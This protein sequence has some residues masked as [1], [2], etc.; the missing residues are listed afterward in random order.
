MNLLKMLWKFLT[1]WRADLKAK[2]AKYLVTREVIKLLQVTHAQELLS[3]PRNEWAMVKSRQVAEIEAARDAKQ[4]DIVDRQSWAYP[5]MPESLHR[6][7]V[8][9]LKNTPYSIRRF[10]ETPIPRR[11]MNLV[12]NSVLQFKWQIKP[13]KEFVDDKDPDR[14]KRIRIATETLKRPN[15]TGES[16][17]DLLE[18]ALEDFLLVGMGVIEHRTTPYFKRPTKMWAVD[19]STIRMFLDWTESAPDRPRYAQMTGLKGE[20]GIVT[21]LSDE[22]LVIRDNIRTATPF[23]LGRMEVGFNSVNAFLGVQDMSAKAGADQIHKTWLWWEQTINTA[24]IQQLR[25]QVMNEL[26]GQSKLAMVAG[27]KA[28]K[29]IDIK[30]VTIEDFML[31]WQKF[32]IVIIAAAFDLSPQALNL[33]DH[34]NKATAQVMADSDWK[35]AVVPVATRFQAAFTRQWLHD[36]LNWKD[37]EFEF[38]NLDD[39]DP[40]T[41]TVIDQRLYTMDAITSDEV[42]KKNNLPPL[43][44]PWGRLT[45]MQKQLL[46]VE[47][48]AKMTGSASSSGGGMGMGA[49]SGGMRTGGGASSPGSLGTGSMKFSAQD[50]ANLSPEM[51]EMYYQLGLLPSPDTLPDQMEAQQPGILDTISTELQEYFEK[52]KEDKLADEV[53]PDPVTALDEKMQLRKFYNDDAGDSLLEKTINKRG[54]LGPNA[55]QRNRKNAVR[56]IYKRKPDGTLDDKAGKDRVLQTGQPLRRFR[57]GPGNKRI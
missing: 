45:M 37:L 55:D 47:A 19:G 34:Q 6:L 10:S 30:P 12:K 26:E 56:G 53:L 7:N 4:F 40:I 5:Y 44:G 13:T 8:P 57:P 28:P 27:V 1:S 25:R 9:V 42:R 3:T 51:I 29:T 24:H 18:M 35:N 23:G 36:D 20:R 32:L 15:N 38:Q 21:F 52:L 41:R 31:D 50:V 33:D 22:L 49:P 39:P 54:T 11:A 48:Q 14:E 17:R 16:F 43:P 46:L 2:T